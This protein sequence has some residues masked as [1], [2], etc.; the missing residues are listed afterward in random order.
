MTSGPSFDELVGHDLPAEERERLLQ[1]H[2]LLLQAGPPAELSPEIEAGPTLAMTLARQKREHQVRHRVG[3]FA[4]AVVAIAIVF[5]GGYIVGN[6]GGSPAAAV[7]TIELRGTSAAPNALASLR[8]WRED[9]SGNWPM[10]LDVTGLPAPAD[11]T[12]YA[13]Y[14][15][16]GR[17]W[18][19]C[20]GF[21][22]SGTR[23][24]AT[25]RLNAPYDLHKGDR[26]VVTRQ[27]THARGHGETVLA[28]ET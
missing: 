10:T 1:V 13:V 24:G 8:I 17:E 19:P 22:V 25:V 6:H 26:W 7:R 20:G 12:R 27:S 18:E 15:V 28:P 9:S 11:D 21:T 2:E 23:T 4:A 16:R 5:L 3:L 14:L